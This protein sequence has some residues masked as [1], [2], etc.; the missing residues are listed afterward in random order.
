MRIDMKLTPQALMPDIRKVFEIA[1]DKI[2]RLDRRWKPQ[3]GAPVFTVAG[4]YTARGWTEW[5]QGFQ[6]GSALLAF[7]AL[8]DA[9]LLEIGR[10]N[11]MSRMA[12]HVTHAGVHD[13]GFNNISTYGNLR[14]LMLDGRI[15]KNEWELRFYELALAASGS[16]QALRWS[17]TLEGLGYVY[18]F[19]GPHSL[20]VDTIRS[21]RIL[22][23]AH[24]LGHTLRGENDQAISLLNRL[25]MHGLSTAKYNIYYG[26]ARDFYDIPASRGRTCHEA[27]FNRNDGRFRCPSS[28]QGYSPFSTW[29]RGLAWAMLGFSEQLE[30]LRTLADADFGGGAIPT[31]QEIMTTFERAAR[32]TCDFYIDHAALDGICYWDTGAPGM[33]LLGDYRARTADPWK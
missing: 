12:A 11:T 8:D 32:A 26:V 31:R 22:A 17:T 16:V 9:A 4:R 6:Y 25:I 20:F 2:M 27:I 29:T 10:T 28:Q 30:F 24:Q 3:D 33:A 23:V 14:R 18:S 13:H 1:G 7:E 15:A 19:N 5:T 21:M